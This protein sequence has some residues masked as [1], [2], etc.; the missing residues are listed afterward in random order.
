VITETIHPNKLAVMRVV[1]YKALI[2]YMKS[3][4]FDV[5]SQLSIKENPTHRIYAR[6]WFEGELR[7]FAIEKPML[8][9]AGAAKIDGSVEDFLRL[10]ISELED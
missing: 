10:L 9:T 7:K 5:S 1:A 4:G 6:K 2:D 3:H 8:T